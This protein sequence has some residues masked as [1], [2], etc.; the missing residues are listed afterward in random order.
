MS[1]FKLGDKVVYISDN[2]LVKGT[3]GAI[4]E[5]IGVAVVHKDDGEADKVALSSLALES[6]SNDQG[7]TE[8]EPVEKSEITIT[9]SDFDDVVTSLMVDEMKKYGPIISMTL[10]VFGAKLHRALFI[11]EFKN[12]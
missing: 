10:A 1:N 3:I 7:E 2:E 8:K 5:H 11:D 4:V 9:P 6:E 12:D